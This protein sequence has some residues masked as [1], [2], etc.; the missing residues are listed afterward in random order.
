VRTDVPLYRVWRDGALA[1]EVSNI[2]HLWQS[3]EAGGAASKLSRRDWVTFLLGCSFSFEDALQQHGLPVRHLQEERLPSPSRAPATD[4]PP[5]TM[6][7]SEPRNVPMF[8]T[9]QQCKPAGVF[10]GPLVV[11]MRPMTPSQAEQADLV[12]AAFPRVHGRPVHAGAPAALGIADLTAPDYG[13]AVTMY[14]GE[15][16]VFWACGVTPQ[17]ALLRARLPIVI[18]H[19]PGH[20]FVTD[21]RNSALAGTPELPCL[22]GSMLRSPM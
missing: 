8:K 15:V 4:P 19:A 6:A 21:Q 2:L 14:P 22:P 20:M 7:A 9:S 10:S 1:E 13:D 3:T 11:S 12:T 17:A 5:V 16:P 18:T